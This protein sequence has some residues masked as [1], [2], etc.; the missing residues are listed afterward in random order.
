MASTAIWGNPCLGDSV[1]QLLGSVHRRS[2]QNAATV[3]SYSPNNS[4]KSLVET[5]PVHSQFSYFPQQLNNVTQ[6]TPISSFLSG[7]AV[8]STPGLT[9]TQTKFTSLR[10]LPPSVISSH[11]YRS[12]DAQ[13]HGSVLPFYP[14]ILLL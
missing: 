14:S 5:R 8:Q 3:P 10:P 7:Y 9:A 6:R 1:P 2:T 4:F 12:E 13:P 11:V